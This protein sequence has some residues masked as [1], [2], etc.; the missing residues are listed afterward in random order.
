MNCGNATEKGREIFR[1][2]TRTING[3]EK[4]EKYTIE[5]GAHYSRML[6]C[7]LK[8][9]FV[10]K[11]N[12]HT[13]KLCSIYHIYHIYEIVASHLIVLADFILCVGNVRSIF[14]RFVGRWRKLWEKEM[15]I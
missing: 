8:I 2:K 10:N 12:E 6:G 1:Q 4:S 15:Q 3:E 14:D 13:P 5:K 9:R 7:L 11:Q